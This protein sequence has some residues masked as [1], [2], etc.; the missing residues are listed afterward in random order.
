MQSVLFLVAMDL[1]L[2]GC[3]S[4]D[5]VRK[6]LSPQKQGILRHSPTTDASK[7]E[8]YRQE[9]DKKATEFCGGKYHITKEYQAQ[10]ESNSSTGVGTGFGFGGG[11]IMVGASSPNRSMYNFIEFSCD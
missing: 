1:F 5:F 4:V 8:K 11:G 9:V 7:A 10:D 2:V 6:D 3:T